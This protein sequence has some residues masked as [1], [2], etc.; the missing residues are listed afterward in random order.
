MKEVLLDMFFLLLLF[1]IFSA[2]IAS[3]RGRSAF[4]WFFIGLF[5]GPFGLL[6]AALPPI[7]PTIKDSYTYEIKPNDD[8]DFN[9]QWKRIIEICKDNIRG[10][11]NG[12]SKELSVLKEI[13][14]GND[15]T[16]KTI[17]KEYVLINITKEMHI[18]ITV[19]NKYI[20]VESVNYGPLV[21]NKKVNVISTRKNDDIFDNSIQE[22]SPNE[23]N[24]VS[25]KAPNSN[26]DKT[27]RLIKLSEMLEKGLI[28]DEEFIQQKKELLAKQ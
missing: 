9:I 8:E 2:I 7:K 10:V 4:G 22:V 20:L 17:N 1:A 18:K 11:F 3:S 5:T 15:Y 26:M 6:V 16:I 12:D 24:K 27:D 13:V 14:V 25:E 21:F 23:D 19:K 28:T